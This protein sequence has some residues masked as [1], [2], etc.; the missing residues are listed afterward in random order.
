M[1][2]S[3]SFQKPQSLNLPNLNSIPSIFSIKKYCSLH[4]KQL[5]YH[6]SI[7]CARILCHDLSLN[8]HQE[9]VEYAENKLPFNQQ[10]LD[11]LRTESWMENIPQVFEVEEF[12][13][14]ELPNYYC[15]VSIIGYKNNQPEYIQIITK[16]PICQ[17]LRE[18]LKNSAEILREFA[19][20]YSENFHQKS[21]IQLLE[22][23]LH[24]AAH[25]LRN[26]LSLIGLYAHNLFLRWSD[27]YYR[28]EAKVIEEDVNKLNSS[29]TEILSCSQGVRLN[30]ASQDL[31]LVVAE[32]LKNFQQII[33]LKHLKIHI[34][35][36][37]RMLLLDKLQIQQV[38]DNLIGNA[39]HFSPDFGNIVITWQAFQQEILIKIS[40]DG[41]G[42]SPE[43]MPK[44]FEPF[45]SRRHG[46]TGL[47]LFIT[48]KIILDHSGTLWAENA[49]QGGAVFSIILPRK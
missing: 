2:T 12:Q 39:I 43:D 37:S 14:T 19:E 29:L 31:K 18:Q 3:T 42:I 46:G 36:T 38:F 25:K 8:Q 5:T 4:A 48:K 7:Y 26:S 44:I 15:Y 35:E 11:Y 17:K 1:V 27:N 13:L 32:S 21:K 47:G 41:P 22:H 45:Y 23:I 33:A 40:D 6:D 49:V 10:T 34:P 28:Q 24:K 30:I 9:T 16:K 20:I